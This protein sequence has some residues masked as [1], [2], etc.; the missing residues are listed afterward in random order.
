MIR[1]A[2]ACYA[3]V[4]NSVNRVLV[5]FS[6]NH[7]ALQAL[8][9]LSYYEMSQINPDTVNGEK[10]KHDRRLHDAFMR[11]SIL[12]QSSVTVISVFRRLDREASAAAYEAT[13]P[14]SNDKQ[15]N[16]IKEVHEGED[17]EQRQSKI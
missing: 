7:D 10:L 9:V 15:F 13:C 5:L 2:S 12:L 17:K 16:S 6:T 1:L 4:V 3:S 8:I 11:I 14:L